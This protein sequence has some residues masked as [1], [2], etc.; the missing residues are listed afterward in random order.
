[1]TAKNCL[2]ILSFDCEESVLSQNVTSFVKVTSAFLFAISSNFTPRG[3]SL[4]ACDAHCERNRRKCVI[5]MAREAK[6]IFRASALGAGSENA[7]W[8]EQRASPP[9]MCVRCARKICEVLPQINIYDVLEMIQSV[10]W[11]LNILT[12]W[13]DYCGRRICS[14][15]EQT[16]W[17]PSFPS[18]HATRPK[19]FFVRLCVCVCARTLFT[20]FAYLRASEGKSERRTFDTLSFWRIAWHVHY[21]L[22]FV[23]T[24]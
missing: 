15:R 19:A 7:R 17:K 13:S 11:H 6:R 22:L 1:M 20:T 23:G 10:T 18:F 14:G 24:S 5:S 3:K 21:Y 8:S 4:S 2:Y 12:S 16:C 9:R